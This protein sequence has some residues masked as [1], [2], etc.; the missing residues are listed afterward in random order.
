MRF[1]ARTPNEFVI[2][3]VVHCPP[4][5]NTGPFMTS[6]PEDRGKPS[7]RKWADIWPIVRRHA[8]WSRDS[9]STDMLMEDSM[10]ASRVLWLIPALLLLVQPFDVAA[11]GR[12]KGAKAARGGGPSFCRSGA[13]HPVFGWEWCRQR[14]WEDTYAGRNRGVSRDGRVV[15]RSYPDR[16]GNRRA[17]DFAFDN[18]YADGYEKGL[19]DGRDR[20]E[21][22]PTRH[23]SY[24]S[25]DHN[26][27]DSYGSRAAY[28][29]VYREGFRSGY[30]AG[31][32]D[33]DRYG[34]DRQ[35]SRFPWPF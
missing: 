14:G 1:P 29:N 22:D 28:A 26:Y 13:G 34:N 17:N 6:D 4:L 3:R 10:T 12:G 8:A 2:A 7:V 31:Y 32:A 5:V 35:A 9:V 20:R 27:D 30:E 11:Q 33:G 18:G 15:P 23:R 21:F 16:Y 19:D 24:R 25:A